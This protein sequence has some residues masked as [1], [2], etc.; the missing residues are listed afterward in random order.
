MVWKSACLQCSGTGYYGL[1]PQNNWLGRFLSGEV[2]WSWFSPLVRWECEACKG[3]G[4]KT[5]YTIDYYKL[6]AADYETAVV[7]CEW[8]V[9]G[10][11]QAAA[12]ARWWAYQN[13]AVKVEPFYYDERLAR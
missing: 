2:L 3:S 4:Q 5:N 8:L 11:N 10:Q 7:N 13:S 12:E 1:I 9:G 6:R